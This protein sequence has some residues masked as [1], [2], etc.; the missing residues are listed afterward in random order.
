M[1]N[2][3]V[4]V[5][6]PVY[7]A[8]NS[9][10]RCLESI[11]SQTY[12]ELEIIVLND[13]STDDSLTICNQFCAK[14]PRV[15]VVDKENEGVSRTRNAGMCAA[16]GKYLQFVDSDDYIEPTFTARM[17]EAAEKNYADLVIAPYWMVIP[18][19]SS[20]S[21]QR[22]EKLLMQLG[23]QTGTAEPEV[24]VYS[25]LPAGNYGQ[26]AFMQEYMKKPSS[27]YF[28]VVWNKLYRRSLLTNADLWFTREV[29][30]EDQLFNVRYFRLAKAYTALADPGYYYIQNPQS[31]LHTNVDLGKIVNSRLQMFP[32]YKQMLTELGLSRGNQ[33]RLY[34]TLIAQSERFTPAGPVQTLLK[35]KNQPK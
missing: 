17:V 8:R 35:R 14:D 34:H 15:T 22:T 1:T 10:A 21:G 18:P 16:H 7:N 32:H 20:K 25:F 9:V 6:V 11:C 13:G 29:Y 26:K 28:N 27:F 30:N 33:L 31:L 2:P 5:I 3:L 23:V 24:N 19:D 12:Q 4:S